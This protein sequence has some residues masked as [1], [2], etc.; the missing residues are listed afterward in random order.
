MLAF[1]YK[2][3]QWILAVSA[4]VGAISVLIAFE[5]Y[6]NKNSSHN[7]VV[8]LLGNIFAIV[9]GTAICLSGIVQMM[10]TEVP[11]VYGT[12]VNEADTRLREADLTIAFQPGV[13]RDD[14]WA[15]EVIGQSIDEGR[16]IQ[17]STPIVVYLNATQNSA[18]DFQGK[19]IV[20]QVTG[21]EQLE[22]IELLTQS[23]LHFQVWWTEVN[24]VD[25][26]KYYIIGQSIPADCAVPA[27]TLIKLEL[28]PNSPQ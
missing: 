16:I 1:L 23:G 25:S 28:T 22:A 18:P 15:S 20:P 2:M 24:N 4:V 3:W 10:F 5:K 8:R 26:E 11:R 7:R 19:V 13:S 14:N 27:G 12:T 21:L 9:V 6:V 17:K